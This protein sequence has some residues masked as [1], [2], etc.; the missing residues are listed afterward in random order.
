M[1][2]EL[3]NDLPNSEIHNIWTTYMSERSRLADS[4]SVTNN[5]NTHAN[6]KLRIGKLC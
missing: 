3:V 1:K 2:L 4:L 6:C 5:K